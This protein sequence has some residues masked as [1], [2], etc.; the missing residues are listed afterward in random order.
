MQSLFR[1]VL[2]LVAVA[3]A[4]AVALYAQDAAPAFQDDVA[5]ILAT[6]C[7]ACHAE[8]A[9]SGLD[10]RTEE[11]ILKGGV[12]GP[13]VIPGKSAESLLMTKVVTGQM[14]PGPSRLAK[15]QIDILRAW[16]DKTLAAKED[17]TASADDTAER[18]VHADER[19]A[20][21]RRTL[22]RL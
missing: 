21:G 2:H 10:L 19:T 8:A 16:I 4:G 15:T 13:A 12:S 20:R 11:S 14:P 5:P 1:C 6:N 3:A 9:Q 22:G 7:I 17:L 18:E